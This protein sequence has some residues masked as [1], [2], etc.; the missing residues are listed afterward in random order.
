M[1]V[2]FVVVQSYTGASIDGAIKLNHDMADICINW[3]GGLHHAK[4]VKTGGGKY[5]RRGASLAAAVLEIPRVM[6]C[7][8]SCLPC[9]TQF[10]FLSFLCMPPPFFV[11]V[12]CLGVCFARWDYTTV[13][14]TYTACRRG[15]TG[16]RGSSMTVVCSSSIAD[17]VRTRSYMCVCVCVF[18]FFSQAEASGF[19][20]VNDI[21]LAILE[22]LKYHSRVL[23]IDI[24]IHHGDGVEVR[25]CCCC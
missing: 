21:V 23:Y 22:L 10:F 5:T 2:F 17:D 20:Y 18:I 25:C 7:C 12:P 9:P 4:K 14:R 19:C 1:N 16:V 13:W 6:P 24:D 11:H 15:Y 3:S 8:M